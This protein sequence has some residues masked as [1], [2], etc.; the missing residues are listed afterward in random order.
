MGSGGI[1][2]KYIYLYQ[3]PGRANEACLNFVDM[4]FVLV[5]FVGGDDLEGVENIEAPGQQANARGCGEGMG[6]SYLL[7]E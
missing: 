4:A 6:P 2:R 7:S 1:L 3:Y 5:G